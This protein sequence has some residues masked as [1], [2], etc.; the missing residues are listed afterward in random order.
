MQNE[1]CIKMH[2]ISK[3]FGT[4]H[5]NRDASLEV[6][7]GE[8]HALLGENGSGKS[9]LMN[10][11]SG[12][13]SPDSGTI[14]IEG[15]LRS[16]SSPHDSLAA[17][18]GMVHQHFKL[19]EVMTAAENISAGCERGLFRNSKR[20]DKKICDICEKYGLDV[21][22]RKKVYSMSVGEK[23][24]VEIVKMLYRGASMFILDEPTAVLTPQEA[25]VLFGILRNMK[26]QGCA[27]IIITHKLN[28]VMEISDRVTVLR[29]GETVGTVNTSETN[30]QQLTELMVGKAVELEIVR[31]EPNRSEKPVL[32]VEGL[33]CVTDSG[34]EILK[35]MTFDI[36]GGEILGVAGIAGSGQKELCEIIAGMQK[37]SGGSVKFLD[38]EILGLSP[39]D[40]L[41]RGVSMSFVPEDR[42]G[43]GL[44]AGMDITNN[45]MLRS[46]QKKK[47]MFV[48]RKESKRKAEDIVER[49][50]IRTPSVSHV[51]R[52]LSGGNIQK[53]LL[54]REV[55]LNPTLLITAYPV[56][57]LDIGASYNIYDILNRQKKDG[58]A[59]LF[60]G[61]DLDVLLAL[62]DR[63]LVMSGGE[64]MDIVDPKTVTK[65]D[66]GL[67]MLGHR[68]EKEGA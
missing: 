4:V 12:I 17:G 51:L 35:N 11:L 54:G 22:P 18:I 66:V 41:R 68:K 26:K 58:V 5:A 64:V 24:T 40:I 23:Q 39:I 25:E 59:V 13:Y 60:I 10:M 16:F 56:R 53:V 45:I 48:D 49:Y 20:I 30:P 38:E 52:K 42:L 8:I 50:G 29:D 37:A 61:E 43:M 65:E 2:G 34:R 57:G 44:V 63:L 36:H 1:I 15:H 6:K 55:E 21:D 19:V 27:I 67:L 47:G 28:E 62:C 32:E 46:F 14:E 3:S 7:R 33:S 9:T 31:E